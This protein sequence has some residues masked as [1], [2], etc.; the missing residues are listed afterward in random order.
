L[1]NLTAGYKTRLEYVLDQVCAELPM[2]GDHTS[3]SF[4]AEKLIAATQ[5]G[6]RSHE[7]LTRV[8]RD[9]LAEL[10]DAGSSRTA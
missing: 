7:D 3:R 8:A 4:I 9:A 10:V 2:G 5:L 6:A 1:S